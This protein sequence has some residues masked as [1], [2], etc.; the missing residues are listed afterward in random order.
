MDTQSDNLLPRSMMNTQPTANMRHILYIQMQLCRENTIA[1]LLKNMNERNTSAA[2][3]VDIPQ[4]LKL[5]QQ[6]VQA[7]TYVHAQGLIHRD[8]KPAN[9]FVDESGNVQV[10]DF[11]LSRES[12]DRSNDSF[13]IRRSTSKADSNEIENMDQTAGVGTRSYAS[14]EQMNGSDYESSTDVSLDDSWVCA[15]S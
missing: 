2:S 9:C 4:A 10:G 6:I 15:S 3:G 13:S 12:A 14:P 1:D 5:F 8:L 7:V 11:G